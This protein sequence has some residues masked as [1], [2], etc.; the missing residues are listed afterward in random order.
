MFGKCLAIA[1]RPLSAEFEER[2]WRESL[3]NLRVGWI[4]VRCPAEVVTAREQVRGDRVTGMAAHQAEAVHQGIDD[5]LEVDTTTT[6]PV[7]LAKS[8]REHFFA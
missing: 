7:E 3:G 5:D 4:V 8:I 6:E 2:R 1:R